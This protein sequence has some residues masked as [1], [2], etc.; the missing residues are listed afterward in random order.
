VSRA[1][2]DQR[3]RRRILLG[4]A[5]VVLVAAF[6]RLAPTALSTNRLSVDDFVEYWAA[7]R[8]NLTGGNPYA[9]GELLPL[10]QAA[11]LG[12]HEPIMMWN[13]PWTLALVMPFAIFSYPVERLLW[14]LL[15]LG[16]LAASVTYIWWYYGGPRR[17]R[18]VALLVLVTYLPVLFVLRMG[19]IAPLMLVGILGFLHFE[20]R[21]RWFLAGA[22][23]ALVA[24][25]P[26]LIYLFWIAQLLW[27]I[28]RRAWRVLL[29]ALAALAAGTALAWLVN[30]G[31]ISQYVAAATGYP[32]SD[33]ATPTLGGGLRFAFGYG[34]FWLQFLPSV[35]GALWFLW[36]WRRQRP[37]WRWSEQM[38]LILLVSLATTP[39]GWEYDQVVSLLA[40]LQV[41]VWLVVIPWGRASTL[42][43]IGYL[44]LNGLAL[45]INIARINAFFFLWLAPSFLLWYLLARRW[46]GRGQPASSGSDP[47]L[48]P[49]GG[50][51]AG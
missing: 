29:G 24:I 20:G 48:A 41:A 38:P 27:I 49:A 26:H 1:M 11:G 5:L 3:I 30:P 9:P 51:G 44:A 7:G 45:A 35:A 46:L 37:A 32:P 33:W 14:L 21:S 6:W 43:V 15:N 47:V 16:L 19:Q 8:L 42:L 18:W 25:K 28:D 23:A 40:I 10:Q 2:S 22:F 13:P 4:I 50:M 34:R 39:Y 12:G 17:Q 36:Y 31:V